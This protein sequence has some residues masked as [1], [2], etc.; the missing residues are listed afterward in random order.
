MRDIIDR[1]IGL[2]Q[3]G[4]TFYQGG[5][6]LMWTHEKHELICDDDEEEEFR[7][8]L[9]SSGTFH[10]QPEPDGPQQTADSTVRD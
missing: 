10:Q 8:L 7:G 3:V 2:V 1:L 5:I 6:S 9:D 4:Q